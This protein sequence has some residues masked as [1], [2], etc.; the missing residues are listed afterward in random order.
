[1]GLLLTELS[2]RWL[3]DYSIR[4]DLSS[5]RRYFILILTGILLL[6]SVYILSSIAAGLSRSPALVMTRRIYEAIRK[7]VVRRESIAAGLSLIVTVLIVVAPLT[8][9]VIV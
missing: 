5:H 4:G 2:Q 3:Y 1:M 9:V 6:L 8:A 7:R